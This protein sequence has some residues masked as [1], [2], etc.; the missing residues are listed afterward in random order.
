MQVTETLADGLKREYRVVVPATDLET[1]VS[2]RLDD[3]KGRVRINGFRP[4][5]VPV[6]HL[7][8]VYGRSVMAETIEETVRETN[9]SIVSEHG[10][11]LA[12]EPKVTLP[13]AEAEVNAVVDGK[14]D[15]SYSVAIEILP[16]IELADFSGIALEK[17]TATVTDE[18]VDAALNRLAEQS[19]PFED[20]GEGAKAETGDKVTVSFTGS[21]DGKPFE[22]GTGEDIAVEIGSNSFIPGFE[23]QLVGI[24]VGETR[25][26][27]ASFPENYLTRELA[28]KEASFEV[29]AKSIA[30]PGKVTVD[31]AFAK[32]LGMESVEK[33]NEALRERITREH[34]AESRRKVKRKLL[35]AL[36]ERH[37][38]ELPPTL[39]EEE[40]ENVWRTVTSDLEA[41]KKTFADENTTEE[42]ARAEYRGI[43]ERRVRLG[44]VLSEIG[45]KN[46]I[47]VTDDE[48]N[49]TVMERARQ[50]PGQEQRIWD[51]YRKS[52]EALASLRAPLY[53]EK[54]VDFLL[55][56]VKTS[57]KTVSR[58]ELYRD[59]EDE[60]KT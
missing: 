55:E 26:V 17:L 54:V 5:K 4:G 41:Q 24:A 25:T 2:A 60:A 59:D 36:D 18:E 38:F 58:E 46:N 50:F 53:E 12:R 20:K 19:R 51:Y 34:A 47:Q 16:K 32:S 37:K 33:L 48:M 10:F 44:L 29:T 31:D 28:G 52:P 43:A 39:V 7:K 3:L 11:K 14:A 49:R 56:L 8:R 15:L 22:G 35:D 57:E 45:A 40:F 1:K 23:E 6:S 27:K 30:A 9:A 13:E 21:I 42:A